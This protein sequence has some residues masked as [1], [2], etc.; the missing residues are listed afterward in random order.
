MNKK[1]VLMSL[2]CFALIT[3]FSIFIA[4]NKVFADEETV[5][6]TFEDVN[7]YNAV[8]EELSDKI[9]S[10]VD[11]TKTIKMTQENID[12]VTFINIFQ[13]KNI[14]SLKGIEKFKNLKTLWISGTQISD[15]SVLS[16]LTSLTWLDLYKNQISD[17]STLSKLTSLTKLDLTDNQISDIN[18]L[19]KLT[20][21]T[22]LELEY[23][24]ISDISALSDLTNLTVLALDN[25]QISNI[26][27]LSKLTNLT[28]LNLSYNQISDIN[29]LS[30]LTSL[31]QL[32]L[33][34]N[35]ISDISALSKLTSLTWL[36]LRYNQ[37]SDINA[38]SELTSLTQLELG[39]NKISDISVLSGLTNLTLLD[40]FNNQISDINALSKLEKLTRLSLN[41]NKISDIS[42]LSNLDRNKC[43][44]LLESNKSNFEISG[45]N[46][47][48][49]LPSMFLLDEIENLKCS[50]CR[51]SEDGKYIILNKGLKKGN[52]VNVTIYSPPGDLSIANGNYNVNDSTI[53]LTLTS[54]LVGG[55]DPE[56][57]PKDDE[58]TDN[59]GNVPEEQVQTPQAVV[60]NSTNPKTGDSMFYIVVVLS[61]A[62]VLYAISLRVLKERN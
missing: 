55:Q 56:T 24:K 53:T 61:L 40:L 30:K 18:V 60:E 21:L 6:I 14:T 3:T 11:E 5:D 54:D 8:K 59:N 20:S 45:D 35:K 34:H 43:D 1:R 47:K 19:S 17:I 57:Q 48:Y 25:N 28:A 22:E 31:T 42:P 29:V 15:I 13:Q 50:N 52:T 49:E 38:L 4:N 12:D 51:I 7:M 37:I 58:I 46:D 62:V 39:Y 32:E 41:G 9:S 2:I 33:W 36:G 27:E 16:E 44:I 26:S 10:S 23:N